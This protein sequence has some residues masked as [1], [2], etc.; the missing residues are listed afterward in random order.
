MEQGISGN[1]ITVGVTVNLFAFIPFSTYT[2][3]TSLKNVALVFR[4]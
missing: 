1:A 2:F 3:L 4:I